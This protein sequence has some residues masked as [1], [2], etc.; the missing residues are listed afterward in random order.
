MSHSGQ[1]FGWAEQ[2][3]A[4]GHRLTAPRRAVL[5][6]L[7]GA[8]TH[9]HPEEVLE[10]ARLI[11][12]GL[13]RATVYRT[14]ALLT[15]LGLLHPIR[16]GGSP[17]LARIAEGHHHLVCLACGHSFSFEECPERELEAELARRFDFEIKGHLL[18]FYGLC[19]DCREAEDA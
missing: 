8:R 4:A 19:P 14:L 2:L 6:V 10:R 16:L 13:G 5:R 7:E 15:D 18:E 12:P 1:E 17:R 9:L 11:Y 3:Q